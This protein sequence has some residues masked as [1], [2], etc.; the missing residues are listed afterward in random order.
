MKK[1]PPFHISPDAYARTAQSQREHVRNIADKLD[2]AEPLDDVDRMMAAAILRGWADNLKD[3]QPRRQGQAPQF[4][5]AN[6][7]I[8]Y[9]C[10]RRKGVGRT[11]AIKQLAE[12]YD[13]T[14]EAMRKVIGE[15]GETAIRRLHSWSA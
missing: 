5:H 12:A 2:R 15:L 9:A 7:A 13:V 8:H 4:D 11:V 10:L 1:L 14:N 3:K 6:A